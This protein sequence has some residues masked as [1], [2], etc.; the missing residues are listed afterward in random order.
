MIYVVMGVCGSGKSTLGALLANA[1]G[2]PF[3][4]ADRFHSA[5]NLHKMEILKKSLDD[6]DRQPWLEL[7]AAKIAEW[8]QDRGAV[9]ACSALK[10]RYRQTL[11]AAC[12]IQWIYLHGSRV[13]LAERMASRVNHFFPPTL[14]DSQ[15]LD[16]EVP[17]YAI[18]VD[19]GPAPDIIVAEIL[20][21][22]GA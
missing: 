5:A 8:N 15:L 19:I 22:L 20:Q 16:L 2:L 1:L 9:L 7:L 3:F 4:D 17:E 13:Q 10:E 21:K 6:S 14:L 12:P 18:Q 11:A